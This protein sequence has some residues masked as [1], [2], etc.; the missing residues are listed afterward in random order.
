M[1]KNFIQLRKIFSI[2]LLSVLF[3]GYISAER[4]VIKATIDSTAILIGE[5]TL[6]H[7]EI[8]ADKNAS[9]QFPIFPDTIISGIEVLSM[10]KADTTDLGN[11][12]I[13]IRQ[14]Y[15]IT[16][17]D[18]ALYLIPPLA[19]VVNTD[20][21][22]SNSLGLKVS[23][24]PVDTESKQF[25]DIKNVIAPPF[26][27]KDYLWILWIILSILILSAVIILL[28]LKFQGKSSGIPSFKKK[29]PSLPPHVKA[30]NELD[31]I[32]IEKIWQ[33]GRFKEYH[34]QI[35]DTLRRYIEGRFGTQAM[36]MT[37]GEILQNIRNLSD[38]DS[39]YDNLKQILQL[40]DFVKFAKYQPLPDENQLSLMNAYLFVN[41]TK[42]EE[43]L[44]ESADDETESTG[45]VIPEKAEN[46]LNKNDNSIKQS[47]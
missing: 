47:N 14:D 6:I 8:S 46:E 15:M 1:S 11:D 17:F 21:I 43:L 28:I 36:E 12:K 13:Q 30:I 26:V 20:S 18:S 34:S 31:Q 35:T 4:P 24:F 42:Q 41:Q 10:Q 23:T 27:W 2:L 25:Y 3:A 5:Q 40:A 45:E 39:A 32:K 37:S 33:H 9:I 22:Y 7:L 44:P 19:V 38:T 29:E 16:S